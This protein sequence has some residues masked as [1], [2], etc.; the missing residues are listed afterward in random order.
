MASQLII[1]NWMLQDANQAFEQGLSA[2]ETGEIVIDVA[3]NTHSFN[4]KPQ[5]VLQVDA[6]LALLVNIVLRDSLIVDDRFTYVWDKGSESLRKLRDAGIVSPFD[7][8]SSEEILT[9]PREEIVNELCVTRSIR[10]IQKANERLWEQRREVEDEHMSQLV[11]G[12]AGYLAR[13]HVYEAPYLGCPFRQALIRETRLV[14]YRPDAVRQ[15]ESFVNTKRAQLFSGLW[16]NTSTNYATFN[17]PPVAIE[18]IEESS[19]PS[20]LIPI[21]T[22]LREKY[23]SLRAWLREYQDALDSEDPK[24]I[25]KYVKLLE[26]IASDI[27]SKY[28]HSGEN[29]LKI[30]LGTSWLNLSVPVAT[31]TG[32]IRSKFGVRAM[33]N[34]LVF[35]DRGEK[36]LRKLLAL[37]GEKN[38]RLSRAAYRHLTVRYSRGSSDL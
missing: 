16:G 5:A 22:E 28:S 4:F 7:F 35:T 38:T 27:D 29:S 25:R 2:E 24:H 11:W 33:L 18:I 31:V 19:D 32:K 3:R 13:S 30:S 23:R 34:D 20:Q 1:D 12:C 10:N 26:S 36:G 21:A 15:V 37:F 9:G 8:L 6:I 17:L 14:N